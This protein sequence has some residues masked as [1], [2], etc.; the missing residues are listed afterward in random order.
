[1]QYPINFSFLPE[2]VTRYDRPTD[3]PTDFIDPRLDNFVFSCCVM[4]ILILFVDEKMHR[5]YEYLHF[6][7]IIILC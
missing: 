4:L 6:F 1:M 7:I 5:D 3:R 2:L